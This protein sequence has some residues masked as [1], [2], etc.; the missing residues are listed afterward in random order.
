VRL[1]GEAD[2][3]EAATQRC[4]TEYDQHLQPFSAW[5]FYP[6]AAPSAGHNFVSPPRRE[7]PAPSSLALAVESARAA[8]PTPM[9]AMPKPPA[10]GVCESVPIIKPPGKA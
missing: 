4:K 2:L 6:A 9:A 10:L 7:A 1:Q 5:T 3:A 8:P